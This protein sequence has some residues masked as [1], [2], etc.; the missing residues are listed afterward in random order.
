MPWAPDAWENARKAYRSGWSL[1]PIPGF[2]H[3]NSNG[4]VTSAERLQEILHMETPPEIIKTTT[5]TTWDPE[6]L[7]QPENVE[8][9]QITL[10]Q[11]VELRRKTTG[12][13]IIALL[14]GRNT[15][16]WSPVSFKNDDPQGQQP[17]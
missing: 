15:S 11:L 16:A 3:I 13:T 8:I 12:A 7:F 14:D 4:L 1:P 9:C 6:G 5:A 17:E 2:V 10:E